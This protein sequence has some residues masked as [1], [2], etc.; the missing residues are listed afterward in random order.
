MVRARARR[1]P[2]LKTSPWLPRC[3]FNARILLVNLLQSSRSTF[4]WGSFPSF[5]AFQE[6]ILSTPISVPG[7]DQQ[8]PPVKSTRAV[9]GTFS[10]L[11]RAETRSINQR[12]VGGWLGSFWTAC[13]QKASQPPSA[14][15]RRSRLWLTQNIGY[16]GKL[17]EWTML[18]AWH[19]HG[20]RLWLWRGFLPTFSQSG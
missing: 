18:K 2:R 12:R 15:H 17:R 19:V 3:T 14:G 5:F 11:A 20:H 10:S 16:L 9:K 4:S 1:L 8:Y 6:D 7:V 13:G